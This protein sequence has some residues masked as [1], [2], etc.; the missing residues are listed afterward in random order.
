MSYYCVR[1]RKEM[2]GGQ[3]G[4]AIKKNIIKKYKKLKRNTK[5]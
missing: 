1:D 4:L 2:V 5:V 3:K